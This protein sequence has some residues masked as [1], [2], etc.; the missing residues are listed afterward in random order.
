MYFPKELLSLI[1]DYRRQMEDLEHFLEDLYELQNE[2]QK[3]SEILI[4][5]ETNKIIFVDD[6]ASRLSAGKTKVKFL[7]KQYHI[8]ARVGTGVGK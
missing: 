4:E 1:H 8:R 5:M 6:V 2:A 7:R 3:I